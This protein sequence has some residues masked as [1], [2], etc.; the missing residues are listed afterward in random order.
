VIGDLNAA[1]SVLGTLSR[2][3]CCYWTAKGPLIPMIVRRHVAVF[4]MAFCK[5][6]QR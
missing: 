3:H 2:E 5:F 6:L 4:W 1:E